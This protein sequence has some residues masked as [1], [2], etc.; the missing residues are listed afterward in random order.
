MVH[1]LNLDIPSK[2]LSDSYGRLGMQA[3]L[4]ENRLGMQAPL[5]ENMNL[6]G[7]VFE[8]YPEGGGFMSESDFTDSENEAISI[9]SGFS[10]ATGGGE[11]DDSEGAQSDLESD[12][13]EGA[14]S[15]LAGGSICESRPAEGSDL[16]Q[17]REATLVGRNSVGNSSTDNPVV[18][19]D[20]HPAKNV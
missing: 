5:V 18:K 17:E 20:S 1:V 6:R 13:S 2:S 16:N 12:D 4:V 14:Q 11:S 10:T 7:G 9:F 15:D 3:P 19:E 8:H